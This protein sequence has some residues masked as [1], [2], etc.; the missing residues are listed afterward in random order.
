MVGSIAGFKGLQTMLRGGEGRVVRVPLMLLALT[1]SAL[2]GCQAGQPRNEWP[3]W[4]GPEQAGISRE[5]AVVTSWSEEGENLL[6][7]VPVGGRSTPIVM[8][9]R[10]YA[11]TP[12]GEG[13]CLQERVICLDADSGKT[14]WEHR[15]NVF[16][17]DIVENR[18]GW[19]SV[20]G[21]PETGNVYAHGTGGELFAFDRD[22]KLLWSWS[23]TEE[24][25]RSSGYG[26]RLH[27]P[28]IDE[29]RVIISF[30]YIL[31]QWGTGPKK[32]GHRYYAF[33]KR[34]GEIVWWAQPG[35]RPKNTTYSTPIVSVVDGKRMLFAP[36][37]DGNVYGLL[38]RTGE[39][40]WTYR[41]SLA[42][43]NATG[44]ADGKYFYV[45][46]SEE[47]VTGTEMGSLVCIDGSGEG[48][49]T[50][51][52]EVWRVD[53]IKAGYSSLALANG[54]VYA[55]ENGATMHAFDAR[56]GEKRW[57]YDLGRAMK[58]SPTV[59]ADGVIYVGEV[60]G[61]FH[62]LRDVG[63]RCVSLDV[64]EFTRPDGLIVEIQGSPA[65]A[66]GRV[67]FMTRYDTYCLGS[68]G[69]QVALASVPPMDVEREVAEGDPPSMKPYFQL[70]PAEVTLAP[71]EQIK[72]QALLFND[73][74]R[75]SGKVCMDDNA[76][77][78]AWQVKGVAGQI[79]LDGTFRASPAN[80]FSAGTVTV[81]IAQQQA[82][83]RVRI[84]PTL[85]I[86]ESFDTM[87]IGKQP[88]GWI[89]LDA[90]TKLVKKDG[91]VVLHK[92]AT[93]P[94]A[95][96]ARMRAY[97]GP[98]LET[99]YTVQA[100]L[101]A[102]P[103][104]GRRPTLSDMGLINS[105]Y[106]MIL[107]AK[108]KKIRLGS[109]MPIPRVQQDVA[110]DWEPNVW[111]TAKLRVDIENGQGLIRAKVWRRGENEPAGWQAELVDPCPNLR[112]SPGLYAYS[113]GTSAKRHGSSVFFDNYQVTRND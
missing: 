70:I 53:G 19:T 48:D 6:W 63:D 23:L 94:S 34:T 54:R 77:A 50:E 109:W 16:H 98:P 99:G 101:L 25:G 110:F 11:I 93:S 85:P 58:G 27:T 37:A 15:F 43:L 26:G 3:S 73:R 86:R 45:S 49:I 89:G 39:K 47:N 7:K 92:L 100:D 40:V 22:G 55:V 12:V 8:N 21:D 66:D 113:K 14:I 52:G 75:G 104:E 82:T 1:L 81:K 41:F 31:T 72:F 2:L 4:R 97:S 71:G 108:E 56:T 87:P 59:T 68:R 103:K 10:V 69:T 9:G 24:L 83:A 57:E 65:V 36:N 95:K 96:F 35:G 74:G 78:D 29:D 106:V 5:Q 44:V 105:R 42:G 107:L 60:N 33:D 102:S 67:Y 84:S 90:K 17:T 38:A 61:I 88:P 79:G 91:S 80:L 111:Y 64:K 46:H 62:I 28:V 76:S 18:L 32:A 13:S 51:T 20:A 112:G 30:T